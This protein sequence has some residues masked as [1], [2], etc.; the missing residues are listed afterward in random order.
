[1][2]YQV[3]LDLGGVIAHGTVVIA[4]FMIYRTLLLLQV[5]KEREVS[6]EEWFGSTVDYRQE[7]LHPCHPTILVQMLESV[8]IRCCLAYI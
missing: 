5:L 2:L 8:L 4:G 6:L 1:M 3:Q 7:S